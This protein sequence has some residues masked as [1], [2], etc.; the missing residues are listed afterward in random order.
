[1]RLV[2][3]SFGLFA[4]RR[5]RAR[6]RKW[7]HHDD[8]A[9]L[10]AAFSI[11]LDNGHLPSGLLYQGRCLLKLS[12]VS[13]PRTLICSP[14]PSSYCLALHARPAAH[15]TVAAGFNIYRASMCGPFYP[16]PH[17]HQFPPSLSRRNS[18][19]LLLFAMRS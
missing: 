15:R 16:P 13:P 12:R 17:T 2:T 19:R 18:L 14:V 9:F 6:E 7:L 4:R 3:T 10:F 5:K 8:R 1:M 11:L